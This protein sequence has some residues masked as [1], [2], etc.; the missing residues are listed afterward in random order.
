MSKRRL[1]AA[2]ALLVPTL[3][4]VLCLLGPAANA[5]E[6]PGV[7]TVPAANSVVGTAPSILRVFPDAVPAQGTPPVGTAEIFDHLGTHTATVPLGPVNAGGLA[8][9]MPALDP[10]VHLVSWT[11]GDAS[12]SFA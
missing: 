5:A 7:R 10:G 2:L 12:G 3:L 9:S 11:A 8:G 1:P 6:D 4:G